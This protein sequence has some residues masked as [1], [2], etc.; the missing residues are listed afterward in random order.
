M[1]HNNSIKEVSSVSKSQNKFDLNNIELS[2]TNSVDNS[3]FIILKNGT[4]KQKRKKNSYVERYL[5]SLR[6]EKAIENS[7]KKRVKSYVNIRNKKN[8]FYK[9]NFNS[10]SN[11]NLKNNIHSDTNIFGKAQKINIF[12]N[13]IINNDLTKI[14]NNNNFSN[15]LKLNFS[16]NKDNN[17]NNFEKNLCDCDKYDN[18]NKCKYNSP[19]QKKLNKYE[20]LI[21]QKNIYKD[22]WKNLKK[23]NMKKSIKNKNNI[24]TN[25]NTDNNN[26]MDN[27]NEFNITFKPNYDENSNNKNIVNSQNLSIIKNDRIQYNSNYGKKIINI[28]DYI[29]RKDTKNL[30]VFK[31]QR[32]YLHY[33]RI[34]DNYNFYERNDSSERKR[35]INLANNNFK[36]ETIKSSLRNSYNIN[37]GKYT[38]SNNKINKNSSLDK[39]TI[40]DSDFGNHK[41]YISNYLNT[42]KKS[43]SN[44]NHKQIN[45]N[46]NRV[47][48]NF[49][50][51]VNITN[52]FRNKNHVTCKDLDFN[53]TKTFMSNTNKTNIKVPDDF[54]KLK[55]NK[56]FSILNKKNINDKDL[57]L[58]KS[59]KT[60]KSYI[61]KE[62]QNLLK[63]NNP[64]IKLNLFYSNKTKKPIINLKKYNTQ[65]VKTNYNYDNNYFINNNY[66]N[67]KRVDTKYLNTEKKTNKKINN[68]NYY[69]S[70]QNLKNYKYKY[71]LTKAFNDEEQK[72][73]IKPLINIDK[74]E[75]NYKKKEENN[76]PK[77]KNKNKKVEFHSTNLNH[78]FY[79]GKNMSKDN[80]LKPKIFKRYNSKNSNQILESNYN[81]NNNKKI[82]DVIMNDKLK[83]NLNEKYKNINVINNLLNPKNQPIIR[84]KSTNLIK[85]VNKINDIKENKNNNN[86]LIQSYASNKSINY[87]NFKI[88]KKPKNLIDIDLRYSNT[89][90]KSNFSLSEKSL[91]KVLREKNILLKKYKIKKFLDEKNLNDDNIS[92]NKFKIRTKSY[93]SIMPANNMDE[94]YKKKYKIFQKIK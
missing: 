55:K 90:S 13:V 10:E 80:Q 66:N 20:N 83:E 63:D 14:D 56:S 42:D 70:N 3:D 19:K 33:D 87:K 73:N 4:I 34:S 18:K 35:N 94:L 49:Q 11:N 59:I 25:I 76:I 31:K 29:N 22:L 88:N 64:S 37:Y 54:E 6:L 85:N 16:Y 27:I 8:L 23:K 79:E 17:I 40:Y 46:M 78:N 21:K 69:N 62:K 86:I 38:E 71:N 15:N 36:N 72:V 48:K 43:K 30:I 44:L 68:Y 92:D 39:N 61:I 53:N 12:E 52:V 50:N 81:E 7:N 65:I 51:I 57:S 93:D 77:N 45:I 47:P 5:N 41:I 28:N 9:K 67:L 2:L 82:K 32:Q 24:N 26:E 75:F 58:S 1:L 89:S 74:Y 60:N 84:Y 91:N